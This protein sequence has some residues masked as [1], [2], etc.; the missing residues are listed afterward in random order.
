MQPAVP[1]RSIR[2]H[3][4]VHALTLIV[5]SGAAQCTARQL[6][7]RQMLHIRHLLPTILMLYCLEMQSAD[8][9]FRRLSDNDKKVS[10]GAADRT[11]PVAERATFKHWRG[12]YHERGRSAR[13]ADA[14]AATRGVRRA[15]RRERLSCHPRAG[16]RPAG[17][18]EEGGPLRA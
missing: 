7:A 6:C 18:S 11:W 15:A 16:H 14:Q 8:P 2:R 10:A 5:W 1:G 9:A 13:E 3:S 12:D 17:G 4:S